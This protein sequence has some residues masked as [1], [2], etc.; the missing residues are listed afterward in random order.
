MPDRVRLLALALLIA[1]LAVAALAGAPHTPAGLRALIDGLGPAAPLA[2]LAAWVVLTPALFPGT[3]LAAA[4]GLVLGPA[5]GVPL[6]LT[7][8]TLGAAAAFA[9]ARAGGARAV[10]GLEGRRLAAIQERLERRG[11]V[12]VAALRA[13]PGMPATALNYAAGLA[14]APAG[15]RGR[16][17]ARRRTEGRRLRGPRRGPRRPDLAGRADRLRR[18]RGDDA[19]GRSR[20][21]A[22]PP[23][24]HC[25]PRAGM[26]A[27][28]SP[29]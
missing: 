2:L 15:L 29:R 21:V 16:R 7:G 24:H 1:A 8:A 12:A 17:G 14:G 20:R 25:C 23:G 27:L 18:D 6:A 10:A 4:G 26:T 28:R 11:F 3:V 9:L 22:G 19:G 13:A 5:L